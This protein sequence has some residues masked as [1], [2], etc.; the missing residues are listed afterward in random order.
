MTFENAKKLVDLGHSF[1]LSEVKDHHRKLVLENFFEYAETQ[2]FLDLDAQTLSD[3]LMSNSLRTTTE[4][5]LLKC[6]L[7]W[8]NHNPTDRDAVAHTV[9]DKIR[10][11]IDG[12][13]TLEFAGDKEPFTSNKKCKDILMWCCQYMSGGNTQTPASRI[14]DCCAVWPRKPW[15][16]LEVSSCMSPTFSHPFELEEAGYEDEHLEKSGCQRYEYYHSDLKRWIGCGVVDHADSRSHCP[17]VEVNNFGILVGGYLY[18]S[19]FVSTHQHCSDE[20]KLF[21]PAPFSVWDLPY[22]QEKRVHH[23]VVHTQGIVMYLLTVT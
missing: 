13:P 14:S 6:A 18:T 4:A 17:V 11:T 3:I 2:E 15:C 12:W 7:K 20:V 16:S 21:T 9:M 19:D 8:Y 10:Y 23:A 5:R 1:G 22:L